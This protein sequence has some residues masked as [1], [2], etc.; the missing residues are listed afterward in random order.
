MFAATWDGTFVGALV[1]PSDFSRVEVHVT[2]T[3]DPATVDTMP[4]SVTRFATIETTAGASASISHDAGTWFVWLVSRSLAGKVSAPSEPTSVT[5]VSPLNHDDVVAVIEQAGT[6]NRMTFA[7]TPPPDPDAGIRSEGD[8]WWQ[9][10]QFPGTNM[11]GMWRWSAGWVP[12]QMDSQ[13]IAN[14]AAG[15]I[16]AGAIQAA[17]TIASTGSIVAGDPAGAAA[18]MTGDGFRVYGVDSD[19]NQYEAIRLGTGADDVFELVKTKGEPPVFAINSDG[20]VSAS[21]LASSRDATIGGTR[22]LGRLL[23][24]AGPTGWID[25]MPQGVSLLSSFRTQ[26]GGKTVTDGGSLWGGQTVFVMPGGRSTRIEMPWSV[27]L[28]EAS[29]SNTTYLSTVRLYYTS[30]TDG[31]VPPDPTTA[32][33]WIA[34][35][36]FNRWPAGSG[37]RNGSIAGVFSPA[38]DTTIKVALFMQP[39]RASMVADLATPE[40][41]VLAVSD[42]GASPIVVQAAPMG[43]AATQK[44]VTTWRASQSRAWLNTGAQVTK[45]PDSVLRQGRSMPNGDAQAHSAILFNAGAISGET[46]KTIAQALAGGAVLSKLEVFI[47]A[48]TWRDSKDNTLYLQRWS[49]NTLPATHSAAA[50]ES[51]RKLEF[52]FQAGSGRWITIPTSWITT[53]NLGIQVGPIDSLAAT[54]L[55]T[56]GTLAGAGWGTVSQRPQLRATYTR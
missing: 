47:Y 4:R 27:N 8:T 42:V 37:I 38:V 25:T 12:Q 20:G 9:V 28:T 48:A 50:D 44:Y 30:T 19:G 36:P 21:S 56:S 22:L 5:V 39:S 3:D 41:F 2:A 45:D 1:A 26:V 10:Q 13:L 18:A 24:P 23:D 17:I 31:S 49:G 15:K 32:S 34:A 52:N 33:S 11:V 51:N 46:G 7:T 40:V 14:L 16:T 29:S 43:G 6:G 55:G 54:V 53:T 35:A